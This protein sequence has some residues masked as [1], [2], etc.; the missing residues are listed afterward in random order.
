MLWSSE[1]YDFY[2][3]VT[4]VLEQ[5]LASGNLPSVGEPLQTTLWIEEEMVQWH[6]VMAFVQKHSR[7]AI[8]CTVFLEIINLLELCSNAALPWGKKQETF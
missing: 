5:H 4:N 7:A 3:N 2:Y 1:C 8:K 6:G